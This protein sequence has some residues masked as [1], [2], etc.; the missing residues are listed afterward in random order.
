MRK[1]SLLIAAILFLTQFTAV[2]A[3]ETSLMKG[4]ET[5]A[6]QQEAENGKCLV[7]DK[8]VVKTI[9]G[10]DVGEDIN[11]Y[12]RASS[13]GADAACDNETAP[14]YKIKNA[15]A[16]YFYGLFGEYLFVDN[17]TGADGRGLEIFNLKS[18]KSIYST[19]YYDEAKLSEGKFLLYDKISETK[20][21]LKNCREAARWKKDGLG[22]GWVRQAKFDL[23]TL[24]EI[25]VGAIRCRAFQ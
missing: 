1:N 13:V 24:K 4:T 22:I 11:V 21:A 2:Q 15:D 14:Y 20:G 16:N 25:S 19:E 5:A 7:F 3:Q 23:L 12:R 10:E 17:G 8:Y 18:K 9:S 6:F